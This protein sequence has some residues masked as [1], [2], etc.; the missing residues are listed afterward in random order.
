MSAMQCKKKMFQNAAE[1]G[2]VVNTECKMCRRESM[3]CTEHL[4]V[5]VLTDDFTNLIT[6]TFHTAWST[7][8]RT[9]RTVETFS[10]DMN[11]MTFYSFLCAVH[12]R[13]TH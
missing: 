3:K 2:F 9:I 7:T 10:A 12:T 5:S 4:F 1:L 6:I 13:I 8:K 11:F